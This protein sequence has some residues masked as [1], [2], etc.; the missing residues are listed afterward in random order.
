[1]LSSLCE[2]IGQVAYRLYSYPL[3]GWDELLKYFITMICSYSNRNKMKGLMMLVEFP[4]EVAKNK[5]FW[6]NQG[7]FNVVYTKLLQYFCLEDSKLNKLAYNGSISLML[8]SKDLQRTDVSEIFL[9]KL[10]NFIIQHRKDEGLVSTLKRLL[11]LLMLDDGS[12]FR[13]K[14]RQVFWCMIQLAELEDS[15]DELRN[16]AV[17]IINELERNSVSAIEGVIKHLSQEEITRVVAVAIN[18]MACIVDD[19]LWSNVYDDD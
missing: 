8:L 7:N 16:K 12:I 5:E 17:N 9:P 11:D 10:L 3:G 18:M 15:S 13:G 19:P 6:L 4:I 14:Q 1:M 2:L